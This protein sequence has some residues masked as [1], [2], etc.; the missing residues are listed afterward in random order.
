MEKILYDQLLTIL[1][2]E[3]EV[4]QGC[5]EP[6]AGA[7]TA[8]VA[9][10]ILGEEVKSIKVEA[11]CNIIKNAKGV[12]IP[13]TSNLMGISASVIL[14]MLVGDSKLKMEVLKN[15]NTEAITKTKELLKTDFVTLVEADSAAKLMLKVTVYGEH[16]Y[17]SA[18]IMHMHTN[19][20]QII[21]NDM[22]VLNKP[23]DEL[24]FNS[25]LTTKENLTL[26]NIL[27]FADCVN[28]DQVELVKTQ[29]EYNGAISNEGLSGI[30]GAQV[31]RINKHQ[32]E[33]DGLDFDIRRSSCAA[34]ASGSDARMSGCVLPVVTVNGSGNQGMT[35]VLP[36]LEYNKIFKANNEKLIRSV[37][38]GDLVAIRIKQST[39][40]LSSLCGASF[41]A[42]GAVAGIL[43]LKDFELAVI[44]NMIKNSIANNTGVIC[45]GAKASCALKIYSG[46]DTAML[47]AQ[48]AINGSVIANNT[49]IIREDIEETIDGLK[50]VSDAMQNVDSAVMQILMRK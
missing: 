50:L 14:G 26:K 12:I 3:M 44:E 22:I 24:D 31:G 20:V 23:C 43:Y 30:W 21:K 40:R 47:G 38:F 17:A 33:V 13:G 45:D 10:S 28:L 9:T 36:I 46:L 15:I 39:G 49:G 27:E 8:S 7:Y 25:A 35:I 19:V 5:T 41:A 37:V 34:A 1:H 48:L 18:M 32:T 11:S 42:I 4:A 2:E 6:I 16:D 29:I